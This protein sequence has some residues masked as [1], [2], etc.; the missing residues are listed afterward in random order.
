[1]LERTEPKVV[2]AIAPETAYLTI[3]LMQEVLRTGTGASAKGLSPNL[4]GKTGTTN[5]NTDAWFIGGSPD[6]IAAVWVG[7][8]TPASLGG[9]QTAA[10][11]ALPIWTQFFGRA[12]SEVPAREF[13]A[14]AGITFARVDPST[15]KAV[16][17]GSGEGMMLPFKLGTV[18]ETGAP[19]GKPGS[20]RRGTGDD[21]L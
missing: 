5:E 3:R 20:P 14:P 16:P 1:V 13:P 17:P 8:D 11:V 10:S 12:L 18:P 6:L 19:A 9:R 7:F 2:P 15:G 4:A 21:L